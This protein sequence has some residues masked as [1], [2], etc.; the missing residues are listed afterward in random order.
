VTLCIL[1]GGKL[2]SLAATAFTLSWTHSVEH[3]IWSETWRVA[4]DRLQVVEARVEGAGAGISLPD[5]AQM[6]PTGWIYQ[7]DLPPLRRLVLAASGTTPSGWSLCAAETCHELGAEAGAPVEIW[8]AP[9]CRL[10]AS[11]PAGRNS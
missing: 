9:L 8:A 6:T 11:A 2:L 1:A 3:T 10:P 5:G 7:P 4:G